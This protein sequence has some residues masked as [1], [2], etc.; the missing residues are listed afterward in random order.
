MKRYFLHLAYNGTRYHGWQIQPNN[1]TVQAVM[2]ERMSRLFGPDFSLTGAGRTDTGVHASQMVAHFDV[3]Q[4]IPDCNALIVKLNSLFPAD[5]S[6]SDLYEV[7]SDA[8]ARFDAVSRRYQY[9]FCLKKNPYKRQYCTR[10][11]SCPDVEAMNQAAAKLLT[12]SDFTSFAKLN[13]NNKRTNNIPT[14]TVFSK[15]L[16]NVENSGDST[17]TIQYLAPCPKF[18]AR[19]IGNGKIVVNEVDID[20][21]SGIIATGNGTL[22][23]SGNSKNASLSNTGTGTIQAEGLY[24]DI[25][26]CMMLGTGTTYCNVKDEISISGISSGKVYYRGNPTEVK[27]RSV[28]VKIIPLDNE[29]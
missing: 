7:R 2:T 27:K 6:V 10:L 29:E 8:H 3:E 23:L 5:I 20:E 18:K 1:V 13:S 28:G 24:A 16:T 4:A 25:V 17:V 12:Y 19:L 11:Y 21:L 15:F 14:I 9:H 26:K 22:T